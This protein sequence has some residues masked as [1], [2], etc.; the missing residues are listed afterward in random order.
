MKTCSV[1]GFHDQA[2]NLTSTI[3]CH[4]FCDCDQ[5]VV[6]TYIGDA[7]ADPVSVGATDPVILHPVECPSCLKKTEAFF[8]GMSFVPVV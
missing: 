5:V 8:D 3:T 4:D 2:F 7:A 6:L 1:F